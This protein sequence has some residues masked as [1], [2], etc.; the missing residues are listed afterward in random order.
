MRGCHQPDVAAKTRDLL[1]SAAVTMD[2]PKLAVAISQ[3]CCTIE[4]PAPY[5]LGPTIAVEVD[6]HP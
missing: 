3:H 2:Q 5:D 6:P 1:A 4:Q